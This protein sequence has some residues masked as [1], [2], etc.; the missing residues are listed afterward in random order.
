M[1]QENSH[2]RKCSPSWVNDYINMVYRRVKHGKLDKIDLY[3]CVNF[4]EKIRN[5]YENVLDLETGND[6][7]TIRSLVRDADPYCSMEE[8]R[9]YQ[10]IREFMDEMEKSLVYFMQ[11]RFNKLKEHLIN[12]L[13]IDVDENVHTREAI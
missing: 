5:I 13:S 11:V 2:S 1:Y 12:T 9:V 3:N 7:S 6:I 10:C 8:R 4:I